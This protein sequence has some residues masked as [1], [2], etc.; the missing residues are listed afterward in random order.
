[1]LADKRFEH[2]IF[3]TLV[4]VRVEFDVQLIAD[5]KLVLQMLYRTYATE[6]AVHHYGQ[7]GA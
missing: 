1:M 2:V 4:V 5:R 7:T 3:G 6:A